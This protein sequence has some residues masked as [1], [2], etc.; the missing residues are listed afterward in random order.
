MTRLR[1]ALAI[2]SAAGLTGCAVGP[3]YHAPQLKLPDGFI[4]ASQASGAAAKGSTSIDPSSWW[5]ALN[6]PQLDSLIERA[7]QANPSLE[8]ALTRLQQ[9]RTFEAAVTGQALPVLEASA[10]AARGPGSNLARGRASAPLI[11]ATNTQG[12]DHIT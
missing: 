3:N 11:S 12:L 9:A 6:D 2:A 10:G 7:I 4:A 5:H 8:I 1:S